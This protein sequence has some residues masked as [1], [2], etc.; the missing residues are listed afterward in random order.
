METLELNTVTAGLDAEDIKFTQA[1]NDLEREF[2][3]NQEVWPIMRDSLK[4]IRI[5][6]RQVILIADETLEEGTILKRKVAPLELL[7]KD[8]IGVL[9]KVTGRQLIEMIEDEHCNL[10]GMS[11]FNFFS[12]EIFLTCD[13]PNPEGLN[14]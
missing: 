7:E 12:C 5:S 11:S 4:S 1:V 14:I 6:F 13:L 8:Y 2:Q 10:P 3:L 9:G